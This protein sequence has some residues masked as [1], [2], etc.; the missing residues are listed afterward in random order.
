MRKYTVW[1]NCGF[2]V[3]VVEVSGTYEK[4]IALT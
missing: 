4:F 1:A 3:V 2:F